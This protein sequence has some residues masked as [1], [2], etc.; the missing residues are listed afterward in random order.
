MGSRGSGSAWASLVLGALSV[1]TLPVAVY[2]TRFVG[3]YDLLGAAYAIPVGAALG[4]AAVALARHAR[5]LS[6]V[7]LER[8]AW[9]GVAQTGR[10][11]GIVGVCMALAGVVSLAVYGLLEY[12]GKRD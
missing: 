7:R 4:V 10:V 1:L 5:R 12:A 8:A 3:S 11:L 6:A 2:V 9:Q